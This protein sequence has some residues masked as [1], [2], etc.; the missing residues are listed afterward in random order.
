MTA[1]NYLLS[2]KSPKNH[3]AAT[4]VFWAE[5]TSPALKISWPISLTINANLLAWEAM[6]IIRP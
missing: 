4:I 6:S 5:R 3:L 2:T 1:L